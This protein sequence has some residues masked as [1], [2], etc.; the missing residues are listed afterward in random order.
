[1]IKRTGYCH[2]CGIELKNKL[3]YYCQPHSIER[4]SIRFLNAQQKGALAAT[5]IV[6]KAI[7]TGNLPKLDGSIFCVDCGAPA[8]NYDHRDYSKPLEVEPVCHSCNLLRGPA[9]PAVVA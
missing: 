5:R 2:T 4:I 1:M 8:R 9:K 6:H 3:A 7:K